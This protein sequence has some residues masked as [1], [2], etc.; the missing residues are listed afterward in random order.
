MLGFQ[1]LI[2]AGCTHAGWTT[3]I[4]AIQK[5]AVDRGVRDGAVERNLDK[6]ELAFTD[7]EIGLGQVS[8]LVD[9]LAGV[10]LQPPA[11]V[12][13][14][15]VVGSI[16]IQASII[17]S[18]V[19]QY[20]NF[21]I[22]SLKLVSSLPY[23]HLSVKPIPLA[24]ALLHRYDLIM[25]GHE[26]SLLLAKKRVRCEIDELGIGQSVPPVSPGLGLRHQ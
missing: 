23:G 26:G 19:E 14:E 15:F 1:I 18:Q 13:H 25:I 10:V 5:Q 3:T 11:G 9:V 22:D 20:F 7:A 21:R 16:A 6:P 4:G 8:G 17:S 2:A 12:S 24:R